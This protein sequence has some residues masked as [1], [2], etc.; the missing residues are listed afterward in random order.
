MI[1]LIYDIIFILK[2]LLWHLEQNGFEFKSKTNGILCTMIAGLES[3][4]LA[5][6]FLNVQMKMQSGKRYAIKLKTRLFVN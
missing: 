1:K 6:A 3:T 2:S 5:F 4:L